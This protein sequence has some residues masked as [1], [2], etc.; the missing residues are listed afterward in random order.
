MKFLTEI[1]DVSSGLPY[2]NTMPNTGSRQHLLD[3][4]ESALY[5]PWSKNEERYKQ[6]QQNALSKQNVIYRRHMNEVSKPIQEL[7]DTEEL[8][9][10]EREQ[11]RKVT[12]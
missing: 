12:A 9:K 6:A 5:D 10:N 1:I 8:M 3:V 11:Q 7:R 4:Q 2:K